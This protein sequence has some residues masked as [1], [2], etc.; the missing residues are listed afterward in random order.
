MTSTT[1]KTEADLERVLDENET[2]VIDFWAPWCAPCR[3]FAP[4]FEAAAERHEGLKFCRVNSDESKSLLRAFG[5]NSIPSLVVIRQRIMVA[6]QPGYLRE[7][8][9]DDLLQQVTALNMD[10]VRQEIAAKAAESEATE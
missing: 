1:L 8:A 9:L 10:A 6:E 5:V 2:V 7:A 3:E 4:L